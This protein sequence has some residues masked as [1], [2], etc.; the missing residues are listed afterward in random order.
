VP[1]VVTESEPGLS[2]IS[3]RQRSALFNATSFGLG[4][5]AD[6]VFAWR[7]RILSDPG[8]QRWATSFPLTRF[9]ARRRARALFD[10]SAGFVYSQVLTSCVRLDLFTQ[11]KQGPKTAA[12][13]APRI[14]LGVEATER[15]LRAAMALRLVQDRGQGKAGLGSLGAALC[16]LADPVALLRGGDGVRTKLGAYWG[17]ARADA[18]AEL[19][20]EQV[21]PYSALMAASN[22]MI[23]DQVLNAYRIGRHRVLLDVGGGEG[24]FLQAAASRA[25]DLRLILFDLPEV[26]N[27]A[28]PRLDATGLI[29]RTTVHGGDFLADTLPTGADV[30]SLIR[31]VHDHDD[32]SVMTLLRAVRAALAPGGTLLLAEPMSGGATAPIADAYFGFYLLAMGSGRA[33]SPETLAALLQR[34]GF[35]SCRLVRT[36]APMLTRLIV[37]RVT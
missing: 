16:D 15:L 5:L 23:A 26:V 34:A 14:G 9:I 27:R 10:L 22:A 12:Q 6:R 17:Y 8:F 13:L 21:A 29:S 18:P 30:I 32:D 25:P 24:A 31:V 2:L 1:A 3:G 28:R 35:A 4:T 19:R 11:L 36:A 33:R 37:A 7:D 20:G